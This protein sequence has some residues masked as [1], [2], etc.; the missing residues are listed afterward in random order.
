MILVLSSFGGKA[1]TWAGNF[2]LLKFD[3]LL[4]LK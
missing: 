4:I 2:T 3:M 1:L